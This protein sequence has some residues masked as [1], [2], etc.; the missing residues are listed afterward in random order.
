MPISFEVSDVIPASPAAIFHAW[1][2]SGEHS[3]MTGSPAQ[4][5]P[6]VGAA[7]KAWDGYIQGK[8]LELDPPQRILQ[9]W[10][11]TEFA[12]DEPDSLLEVRLQAVPGGTRITVHH[13][14]LPIH[15]EQYRA[16]WFEH[17]FTP[18]KKY[19]AG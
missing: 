9:A 15:G 19:F 10:R 16:G 1:L 2:N 5:S 12:P 8:T 7:F 3:L 13:T 6:E 17:Y 18:M 14:N 11:T 4:A